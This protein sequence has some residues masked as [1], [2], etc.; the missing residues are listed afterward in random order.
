MSSSAT[1]SSSVD[2]LPSLCTVKHGVDVR[3]SG[4]PGAG[5]GLFAMRAFKAGHHITEY[6][7]ERISSGRNRS[8]SR[9]GVDPD[10][11]EAARRLDVQ[12]HLCARR[13][14][15]VHSVVIDGFKTPRD[16]EGGGSF[17][18]ASNASHRANA[19]Y[20]ADSPARIVLIATA[21]IAA[22]QEIFVNYGNNDVAMG[23]HR[24]CAIDDADGRRVCK[25]VRIT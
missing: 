3:A 19:R 24:L 23:T 7:G 9:Y 16:G 14:D 5:L 12:T 17:A 10:V 11:F 2:D 6:A 4:L 21:E 13:F 1:S 22:G 25:P 8:G 18:N 20:V 15:V